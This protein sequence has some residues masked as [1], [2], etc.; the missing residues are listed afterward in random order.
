[1]HIQLLTK[2]SCNNFNRFWSWNSC[3]SSKELQKKGIFVRVLSFPSWELF[4]K[5]SD[6]EKN[7]ILGKKPIFAIEAAIINGWEKYVTNKNFIGM[8]SFGASGPYKKLYDH[9]GI[10]SKA[11]T[12]LIRERIRLK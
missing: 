1:M 5:L 8:K 2:I 12:K 10:N 7:K 4:D 3:E 6:K 9:F 11:L